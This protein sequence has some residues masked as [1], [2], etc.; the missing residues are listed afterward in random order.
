MN[1][2]THSL[3]C[4]YS[5][6]SAWSDLLDTINIFPVA[7]GDT[8]TNLRISLAPFRDSSVAGS[9]LSEK[10]A[11][12]ATGNSGNIAAAFFLE[13]CQAE[14]IE[15]LAIAAESG[16]KKA[17]DVI[18]DPCKG[19]IL[20]VFDVLAI[21]LATHTEKTTLYHPIQNGLQKTVQETA[22][23]LPALKNAKVVDA[24]ALAMY[25][26]FEGF[27]RELCQHK[28][29]STS[30]FDLF[31]SKLTRDPAY[32]STEN[33]NYCIDVV[34]QLD[35]NEE[36][37]RE[38]IASLGKS[39]VVLQDA[40]R[41]KVHLHSPNPEEVKNHLGSY[42]TIL[43]WSDEKII[44]TTPDQ[45][46]KLRK[47]QPIHII[48]DA[49]GSLPRDMAAQY[50]ITLLD[51][52]ITVGDISRPESLCNP[53]EIYTKLRAGEKIT[54]AQAST[55]ERQLHYKS[56]CQQYGR[57]LYLCVGSAFTGNY[58][59]ASRWAE[60]DEPECVMTVLDTGA[61]S[62]RLGL[63]ALLTGRYV[64]RAESQ[65]QVLEY[66]C[67]QIEK[68][69]E[70]VFID[71]L[72][73]LV[74]GGR[75]PKAKGFFGDLLKMKPVISPTREGV[76]KM[77][78]VRSLEGQLNF[79]LK[80]LSEQFNPAATPVIMLQYSDNREWV[81]S[82]VTREI[83]TVLPGAEILIVP[84]SLTSGVHMG[85]GTWSLAFTTET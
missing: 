15:D 40:S 9:T 34:M 29:P 85:P 30:I 19:T 2:I 36:V 73:Y 59:I 65:D 22:E 67:Q 84:L 7:D 70:L 72:K 6:L 28:E 17:W 82:E 66:A 14:S 83:Q 21:T 49:A 71:E 81:E 74:A 58:S 51:S 33:N 50:G 42:G 37:K 5:C 10:L 62:G 68:C 12:S 63:V 11:L 16:R 75:I 46:E 56:I 13:F 80:K 39:G 27:F 18:A 1:E 55:Y 61:A 3:S 24:G 57:S 44:E 53:E 76:Q 32:Q 78:V 20:S 52:Y 23:I 79:G 31:G 47:K 43:H 64:T 41:L 25:I 26:F 77:G 45:L 8:G 35:S 54:T 69:K 4:G 38:Q 48:T 60:S